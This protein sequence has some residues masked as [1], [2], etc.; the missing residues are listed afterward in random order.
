MASVAED[1]L[2]ITYF[3]MKVD[4][5]IMD[6]HPITAQTPEFTKAFESQLSS[7]LDEDDRVKTYF[8]EHMSLIIPELSVKE[9]TLVTGKDDPLLML[10]RNSFTFVYFIM[11]KTGLHVGCWMTVPKDI[12]T[13][14]NIKPKL[15]C[16]FF[17]EAITQKKAEWVVYD[18]L[19]KFVDCT[20][21]FDL[22]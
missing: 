11:M 4:S 6:C 13:D 18:D 7:N 12:T 20:D 21:R 5:G 2:D 22:S 8:W 17:H 1:P 15:L 19:K 9:V 16:C 10:K 3:H 14:P